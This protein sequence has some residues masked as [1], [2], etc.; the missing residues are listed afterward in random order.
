LAAG[1]L[2]PGG[3]PY[4]WLHVTG[5]TCAL[6][7]APRAAVET[8][9]QWA[10]THGCMVSLDPNHRP[11][12]WGDEEA[13]AALLPLVAP[14]AALL[15]SVEDA[16]LLFGHVAPDAVIAAA[17]AAGART[18]VLKRG[19]LGAVASDGT[20]TVEVPAVRAAA[21]VDP[22]GRATRSTP[23]SSPPWSAAPTCAPPWLWARTR[24]PV[25]W[26]SP[27]STPAARASPTSPTTCA[28]ASPPRPRRAADRA[29]GPPR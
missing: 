1:A 5:I 3:A 18:V 24:A 10:G 12:L 11:Q 26:R 25:P 27:A 7:P 22:V 14:C 6:G 19:P 15:L 8:A 16:R 20:V 9:V 29:A 17:R 13:R 4:S 28:G 23:A 21:P 2:H